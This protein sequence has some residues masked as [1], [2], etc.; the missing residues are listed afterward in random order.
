MKNSP[1]IS[2]R[3]SQKLWIVTGKGGV[4]KTTLAGTLGLLS[5]QWK[6]DTLLVETH[7]LQHLGDLMG[8]GRVGY[9]PKKI[10]PHL[11]LCQVEPEKALEEYLLQQIKVR[12][13]Y[14]AVFKN[15]YV[16]HFMDAAPGLVELLTIGKIWAL[17]QPKGTYGTPR[18]FDRVIVDAPSTGH[19]LSLLTVPEVVSRAVR[20]GPLKSKSTQILDVLRNPARTLIWL[21]TLPEELPVTE[22]AEM[23]EKLK[24]Q[25]KISLGPVLVNCVWP[26]LI[27]ESVEEEMGK[28]KPPPFMNVYKKRR[29]LSRFYLDKLKTHFP[30]GDLWTLPLVYR[31][32]RPL[33]IAKVLTQRIQ[34]Q[35]KD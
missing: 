33:E 4:G 11:W 13:I 5:S 14:N 7:G 25:V 3:F 18:T 28:L 19:G 15:R 17:T 35:M 24:T 21:A 31:T 10:A 2:D 30:E 27:S 23:A 26:E 6:Q 1:A 8:V 32:S 29:S 34:E 22:T 9:K 16:R 20:V 12:F